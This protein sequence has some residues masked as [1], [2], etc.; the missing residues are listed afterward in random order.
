M[1]GGCSV[2]L[3]NDQYERICP[4]KIWRLYCLGCREAGRF[5]FIVEQKK[6]ISQHSGLSGFDFQRSDSGRTH[7]HTHTQTDKLLTQ[8]GTDGT[9]Q[10]PCPG[11]AETKTSVKEC[12]PPLAWSPSP[13]PPPEDTI[14]KRQIMATKRRFSRRHARVCVCV[15]RRNGRQFLEGDTR[16][17]L[18]CKV[19]HLCTEMSQCL[20]KPTRKAHP[21]RTWT[22]VCCLAAPL[23]FHA[24][25]CRR[26]CCSLQAP[27]KLNDASFSSLLD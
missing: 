4:Y 7:T 12:T 2:N 15:C 19:L 3:E 5:P 6:K 18:A 1:R 17:G 23:L 21:T 13:P 8:F 24:E 10:H 26:S 27:L 14:S 16:V 11:W 9:V 25:T 20:D 22:S